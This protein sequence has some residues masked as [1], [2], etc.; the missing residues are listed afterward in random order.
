M[1]LI[2]DEKTEESKKTLIFGT[3]VTGRK[4]DETMNRN[5]KV[6]RKSQIGEKDVELDFRP[7]VLDLG[8]HLSSFHH[9]LILISVMR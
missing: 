1:G 6:Q 8:H 3:Q 2:W 4:N 5:G 9:T 7:E